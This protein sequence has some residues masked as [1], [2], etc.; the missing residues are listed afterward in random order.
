LLTKPVKA[1]SPHRPL[2]LLLIV[3]SFEQPHCEE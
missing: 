1:E 2:R 3:S